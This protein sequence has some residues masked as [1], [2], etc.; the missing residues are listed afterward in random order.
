VFG[1]P[2]PNTGFDQSEHAL[3]TC[4]FI[5]CAH[6]RNEPARDLTLRYR[7]NLNQVGYNLPHERFIAPNWELNP[8]FQYSWKIQTQKINMEISSGRLYTIVDLTR[9]S[10][11]KCNY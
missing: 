9:S 7:W 6:L 4:Y 3:Y 10:H 11:E 1:W 2:D 5:I 8:F